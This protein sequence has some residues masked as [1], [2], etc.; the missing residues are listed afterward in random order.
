MG[1]K[2][3][4]PGS[5]SASSCL[6]RRFG[7]TTSGRLPLRSRKRS[8]RW[9]LLCSNLSCAC[10]GGVGA[11]LNEIVGV[12]PGSVSCVPIQAELD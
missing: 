7:G 10:L 6:K 11:E 3:M 2:V 4:R 5:I 12:H 8:Y 1:G 9:A